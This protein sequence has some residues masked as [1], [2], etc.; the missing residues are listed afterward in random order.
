MKASVKERFLI[1]SCVVALNV[2]GQNA[3]AQPA[4]TNLDFESPAWPNGSPP[5]LPMGGGVPASEGLPGWTIVP[6]GVLYGGA[7]VTGSAFVALGDT[8]MFNTGLQFLPAWTGAQG[9]Y[10]VELRSGWYSVWRGPASIAQTGYVDPATKTLRF[11]IG[12]N[13][14]D[15]VVSLSGQV[16]SCVILSSN[17]NP[18]NPGYYADCAADVSKFAGATVEL[19][20]EEPASGP[21]P[22]TPLVPLDSV[23]FSSEPISTQPPGGTLVSVSRS[24]DNGFSLSFPTQVSLIYDI[25]A[26]TNLRNWQTVATITATNE[27]LQF[28]D[29]AVSSN[30]AKY[31]RVKRQ[32]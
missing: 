29:Y 2:G 7:T 28:F 11:R 24:A 19:K 21:F 1:F 10:Y 8:N 15:L 6:N 32:Q 27:A 30:V 16:L 4:F 31:Y 20:F 26:T 25:Q 23:S 17:S 14:T 9:R 5:F 3:F 12:G 13:L 22:P 18:G